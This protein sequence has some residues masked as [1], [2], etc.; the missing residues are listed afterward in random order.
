[1]PISPPCVTLQETWTPW[2]TQSHSYRLDGQVCIKFSVV[3]PFFIYKKLDGI[4]VKNFQFLC[5]GQEV[6]G[7]FDHFI[8]KKK[9]NNT[10]L[11]TNLTVQTVHGLK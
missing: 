2:I 3:D 8:D 7:V 5:S 1:M 11:N 10:K 6:H 4:P 9:A